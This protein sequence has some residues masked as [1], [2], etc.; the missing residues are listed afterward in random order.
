[1]DRVVPP[2]VVVLDALVLAVVLQLEEVQL[3]SQPVLGGRLVLGEV[4]VLADLNLAFLLH[5]NLN[6]FC[7]AN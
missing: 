1:V 4:A 6:Y 7:Y 3:F 5:S 2:D